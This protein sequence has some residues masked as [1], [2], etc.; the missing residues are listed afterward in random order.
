MGSLVEATVKALIEFESDL[1]RTKAEALEVKKKMI[2]DAE[3]FAES[4]KLDAISKAQEQASE[5]LAKARS[6]AE[7]EAE[8]IRKKGSSSLKSY[9]ALISRRKAKAIEMVVGRL[10]GE[11]Q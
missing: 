1:D 4:A 9:E 3:A 7:A 10:L 11:T 5:T 8:T 2:K 6:E